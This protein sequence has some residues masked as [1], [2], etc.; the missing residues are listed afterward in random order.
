[1]W[2]SR[3]DP[4]FVMVKR[5]ALK[6]SEVWWRLKNV[7][8]DFFWHQP[9]LT[10]V[11][12][13]SLVY[14]QLPCWMLFFLTVYGSSIGYT[15]ISI[16]FS[17]SSID[18]S[19]IVSI[20]PGWAHSQRRVGVNITIPLHWPSCEWTLTLLIFL[21]CVRYQQLFRFKLVAI[22]VSYM[23]FYFINVSRSNIKR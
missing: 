17:P 6:F 1:M 21:V 19:H 18:H 4:L 3:I 16:I 20:R 5:G 22:N 10:S 8:D 12:E 9:T 11:C 15:R 7:R 23:Y 2:L 13:W 14:K